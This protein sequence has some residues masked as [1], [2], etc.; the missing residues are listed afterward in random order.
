MVNRG[1]VVPNDLVKNQEK[2]ATD[3]ILKCRVRA[4]EA[5]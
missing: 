2:T 5:E 1:F 4:R 3:C